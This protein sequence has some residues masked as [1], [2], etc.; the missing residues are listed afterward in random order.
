VDTPTNPIVV[1]ELEPPCD[2]GPDTGTN[3]SCA[4]AENI[5]TVTQ[6]QSV[7]VAG[8]LANSGNDGTYLNANDDFDLYEFTIGETGNYN[9]TLDCFTTGTDGEWLQLQIIDSACSSQL[10]GG[11][12]FDGT[13]YS[14]S[15][16]ESGAG[17]TAGSQYILAVVGIAGTPLQP[18]RI[19]IDPVPPTPTPGP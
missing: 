9:I 4:T 12:N 10:W 11:T 18:Y 3:D 19:S 14:T 7:V 15:I 6:S 17:L 1:S 8:V 13:N 2:G 5:G 16:S